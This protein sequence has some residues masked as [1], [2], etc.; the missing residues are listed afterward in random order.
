MSIGHPSDLAGMRRAGRLV[1]ETIAA[2]RAAVRPGVT[3]AAL[4]A[5]AGGV[6]GRAGGRSAPKLV[7]RF[8]GVTCISVNDEAVHGV[9]GRRVLREGDSRDPG[10]D[11]GARRLHGRR[12]RHGARRTR[13]GRSRQPRGRRGRRVPHRDRRGRAGHAPAGC[14]PRDRGACR[15]RGLQGAP[16]AVRPRH[17]PDDSR[18]AERREL[19]RPASD[20][21]ADRGTRSSRSSPSSRRAPD[22]RDPR[23]ATGRSGARTAASRPITNT[24]SSSAPAAARFSPRSPLERSVPRL[25]PVSPRR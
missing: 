12:G 11:G 2:M 21:A 15:A 18:S 10:R 7:Y 4:D 16:R 9:P 14:W 13:V 3:T 1:A 19:R 8:P 5:I 25:T 6:L 24:Q 23:E 22:A 17:R 20:G